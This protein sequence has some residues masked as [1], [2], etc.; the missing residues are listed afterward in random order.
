MKRRLLYAGG[1]LVLALG[2]CRE[3]PTDRLYALHLD[4][5]PTVADWERALPRTVVVKGGQV[6]K[7]DPLPEI[8]ADTVHTTTASCHH[9]STP[10]A[11][12][13]VD[14]R[15]F[16]TANDLYLRIS[17]VDATRDDAIR[18]WHFDGSAWHAGTA[19]ED[20]F[21]LLWAPDGAYPRFSCSYACHI[22]DFGVSGANFHAS[23]RMRLTQEGRWLD[24]W[25]WKA[26]R[27]GRFGFADDRYL[28]GNGMQ[29][30][31][32]GELF[33]EN[34]RARAEH[35]PTLQPLA[36]GDQPIY[37]AEGLPIGSEFRPAGSTAPGYLTER[38]LGGRADIAAVAD[39]RA[40][41]W[42][43]ILR[44]ALDTGDPHDIRFVPGD[45]AGTVFGLSVM[46]DTL[47][48]HYASLGE[49]RL[50]LLPRQGN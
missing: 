7:L 32:P 18:Q 27:T 44:R 19:Q 25:N 21:G 38:P 22:S 14:L 16:Y 5:A 45:P 36:E 12:L 9:G 42:T 37:D 26:A 8:D 17:W 1:L 4:R 30:D 41:R 29:G 20:G 39:Y 50:I 2:A 43:V 13:A 31:T 11:P 34:S 15:A 46:D 48:E 33:S 40:G 47:K 23:N 24:L 6:H 3:I 35:D 28:D 10:P 49:E